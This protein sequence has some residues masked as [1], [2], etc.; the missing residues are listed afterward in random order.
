M[1]FWTVAAIV[2]GEVSPGQ[3]RRTHYRHLIMRSNFLS[4]V[5][6]SDDT[7]TGGSASGITMPL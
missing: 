4:T 2:G 6:L 5:F 3:N 7:G 1:I